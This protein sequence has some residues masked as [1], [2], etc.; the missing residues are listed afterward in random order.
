MARGLDINKATELKSN[1]EI[2][3]LVNYHKAVSE[4]DKA[5]K[6]LEQGSVELNNDQLQSIYN[7]C[8]REKETWRYILRLIQNDLLEY[9]KQWL[10]LEEM[11][12]KAN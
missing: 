2:K 6:E 7:S 5:K 8:I 3:A 11:L 9:K 10:V 12:N 4:Y 1:A